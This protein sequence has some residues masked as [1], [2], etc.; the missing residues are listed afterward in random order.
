MLKPCRED[1]GARREGQ[2]SWSVLGILPMSR[3]LRGQQDL[4]TTK[5]RE[6]VM[7]LSIHS[8]ERLNIYISQQQQPTTITR[9]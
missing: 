7:M 9:M 2:L 5:V 8:D 4:F 6:R 1:H 3:S